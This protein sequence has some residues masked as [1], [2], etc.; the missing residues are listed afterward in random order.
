VGSQGVAPYR[1]AQF[2]R[3]HSSLLLLIVP[4]VKK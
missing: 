1:I 2:R 3:R 4:L